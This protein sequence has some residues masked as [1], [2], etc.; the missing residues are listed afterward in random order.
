MFADKQWAQLP[1]LAEVDRDLATA[2]L[3]E[4]G[5]LAAGAAR[6]NQPSDEVG[7][8]LRDGAVAA[9]PGFKAACADLTRGGCP[10]ITGNP[11]RGQRLRKM[12]TVLTEELFWGANSNLY[13]YGTLT[14]GTALCIDARRCSATTPPRLSGGPE[15]G[16]GGIMANLHRHRPGGPA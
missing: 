9:P 7:P 5:K 14:T 1:P 11:A 16:P 2:V 8:R 4:A 3:A 13:L 6:S 15:P 10:D 12:L